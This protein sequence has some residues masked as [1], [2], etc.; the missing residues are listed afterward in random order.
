MSGMAGSFTVTAR[1]ALNAP[2][3]S[4]TGTIHFTSSDSQAVLPGDYTFTAGDGGVQTFQAT[5]Y[6]V[7]LQSITASDAAAGIGGGR[8]VAFR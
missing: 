2:P 5:L 3:T 7:G 8:K 1:N 4:Y 6:T